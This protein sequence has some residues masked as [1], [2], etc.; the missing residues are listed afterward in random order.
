MTML[1][2]G[3]IEKKKN[4]T[5]EYHL[6]ISSKQKYEQYIALNEEVQFM[7]LLVELIDSRI[8]IKNS[9]SMRESASNC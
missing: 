2:M 6:I 3:S 5:H 8:T 4:N 7:P 1:K 9:N